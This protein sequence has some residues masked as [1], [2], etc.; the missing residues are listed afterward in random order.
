MFAEA[1]GARVYY[2]TR[3]E[4]GSPVALLHGWG[5][6]TKMMENLAAALSGEHRVL[7]LDFPGHGQSG[8]PPEP[9]GVPEYA[10]CLKDVLSQTDFLPC[11]AVGHSFGCRVAAWAASEWPDMF[12]KLVFTGARLLQSSVAYLHLG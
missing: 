4:K 9:W 10:E 3:G 12:T 6:S 8:R 5:C 7:M 2:E 11:A 1:R